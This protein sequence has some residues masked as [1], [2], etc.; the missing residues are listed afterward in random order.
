MQKQKKMPK[1]FGGFKIKLYLCTKKFKFNITPWQDN[2]LKMV[3]SYEDKQQQ[4]QRGF[5]DQEGNA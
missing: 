4:Q 5:E 3:T 1:T 2:R